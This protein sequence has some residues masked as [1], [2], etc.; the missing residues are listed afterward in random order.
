L[1]QFVAQPPIMYIIGLWDRSISPRFTVA[2]PLIL[3]E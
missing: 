1:K 2:P 3:A